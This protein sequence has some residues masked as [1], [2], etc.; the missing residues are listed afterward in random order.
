MWRPTRR[1]A[2]KKARPDDRAFLVCVKTDQYLARTGAGVDEP[3]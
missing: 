1:F 2:H 3:K